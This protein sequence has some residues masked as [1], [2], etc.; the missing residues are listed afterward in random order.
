[1][2]RRALLT[3]AAAAAMLLPL[4][5]DASAQWRRGRVQPRG[6]VVTADPRTSNAGSRIGSVDPRLLAAAV[7]CGVD[8]AVF[9]AVVGFGVGLAGWRVVLYAG[10][11]LLALAQDDLRMAV[12]HLAGFGGRH[13]ALGAHKQLLAHFALERGQLLAQRRLGDEKDLGGLRQAADVHDLHEIFEASQVHTQS[14]CKCR[15]SID[16]QS[17]KRPEQPA[18]PPYAACDG[19]GATRPRRRANEMNPWESYLERIA[20]EWKLLA[21]KT[22][23]LAAAFRPEPAE[24]K[25]S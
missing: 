25:A 20:V 7:A 1:M 10:A 5:G 12:Q 16:L 19:H 3:F 9:L 2:T 23:A 18:P 8:G 17:R 4:A 6:R 24:A 13:A 22:Q 14:P 15:G 21:T 11:G